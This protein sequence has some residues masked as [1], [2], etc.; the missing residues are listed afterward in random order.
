MSV[1]ILALA[2][3]SRAGS[4]NQKLVNV[5]AA[6]AAEVGAETTVLDLNDFSMPIFNQDL[7]AQD[8]LPEAAV[9][10]KEIFVSHDALLIASPE[11]NS[12]ITPLLKNTI[13]WVSRSTEGEAPLAAYQNKIAGIMAAS[14]G[15]LGGLRGLVHLR[16]ILQNIGV[17]VVPKQMAIAKAYEAFA[18]DGSLKDEFQQKTVM[19]IGQMVA[20]VATELKA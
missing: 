14:P 7:E 12:S 5:A 6:G 20:K 16:A 1:K 18:E 3:S 19:E 15:G 4:F 8:G 17:M 2:G 9:R 13:D 11:Y 10:L